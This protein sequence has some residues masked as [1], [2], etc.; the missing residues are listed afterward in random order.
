MTM[1]QAV[2]KCLRKYATF[3]GRASRSEFW[4]FTLLFLLFLWPLLLTF[5]G[6]RITKLLGIFYF[7]LTLLVLIPQLAVWTRR[8]HD[9]GKRGWSWLLLFIPII[10]WIMIFR[11]L[12]KHGQPKPN[13]FGDPD[14]DPHTPKDIRTHISKEELKALQEADKAEVIEDDE[15]EN[16]AENVN[17]YPIVED[18]LT[19]NSAELRG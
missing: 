8:M 16:N 14:N 10:G 2:T 7:T 4:W 5:G 13:R 9:V 15:S 3:K 19:Q 1:L 6:D 18:E 17:E 11:R 12:T